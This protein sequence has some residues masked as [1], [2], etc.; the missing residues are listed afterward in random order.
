MTA[1]NQAPEGADAPLVVKTAPV[2][3]TDV[4]I[5]DAA[6]GI[7][8]HPVELAQVPAAQA[9]AFARAVIA[10]FCRINGIPAP[11]DQGGRQ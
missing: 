7:K 4:Q 8:P 3:L 10:A 1:E 9:L 5:A 2:A 11:Q 6:T